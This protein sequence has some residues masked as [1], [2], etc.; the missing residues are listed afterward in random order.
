[1]MKICRRYCRGNTDESASVYNQGMLKVFQNIGQYSGS[2]APEAWIRRI[3]VNSCID[4]LRS[5]LKFQQKELDDTAI[6]MQTIIPDVYNRISGNEIS[7]LI[8]ELPKNTGLVF[9]LF[10]IEGY[11]HSEIATI[12]GI[13]SGTSKWHLNEARKLLKQKLELIFKKEYLANAI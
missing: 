10:A 13:S 4:H 7:N 12:L 8:N 2:G 3:I 11:K 9:N 6:D 1:M 5:G